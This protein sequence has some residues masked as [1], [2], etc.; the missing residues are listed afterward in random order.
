MKAHFGACVL[1]KGDS[2]FQVW[3]RGT[4]IS[5][6]CQQD[7][8]GAGLGF[9]LL[10][11]VLKQI[12]DIDFFSVAFPCHSERLLNGSQNAFYMFCH[13]VRFFWHIKGT[14]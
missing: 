7:A 10:R 4:H 5:D 12:L 8:A 2:L 9:T 1:S 6:T 13:S 11:T 14:S 3:D